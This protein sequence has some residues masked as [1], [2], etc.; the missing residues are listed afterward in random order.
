MNHKLHHFINQWVVF[1]FLCF[2]CYFSISTT[3]STSPP[4]TPSKTTPA[5]T[6]DTRKPHLFFQKTF[7]QFIK[8]STLPSRSIGIAVSSVLS[9][10]LP[11]NELAFS[12]HSNQLFVPASLSKIVTMGVLL[13]HFAPFHY[14]ETAFLSRSP[15]FQKK[16]SGDLYLRG[17]G[18]PSFV[19]ESLWNLVNHLTRTNLKIVTGNLVLDDSLF[20]PAVKRNSFFRSD[21]SFNAP[22]SA[23]SFNWNSVNVYVRPGTHAKDPVIVKADPESQYIQVQNTAQTTH[24]KNKLKVYRVKKNN[25]KDT[26][27]V[28]GFLPVGTKEKV[29]YKNISYPVWWTGHQ[30]LSFLKRRGIHIE[31]QL[32]K[33]KTPSDATVMAIQK[34]RSLFQLIQDMMKFSSNFIAEMLMIQLSL[35]KG[36]P[37]GSLKAGL[38]WVDPYLKHHQI[39]K[40]VF[41]QPSGLSRKNKLKPK[42]LLHLLVKDFYSLSAYEK[43]SSY[44]VGTEGTLKKRFKNLIHPSQVRA[45]TGQLSGVEGLA[46]YVTNQKNQTRAFVFIYNGSEKKKLMARKLFDQFVM[47][48][49]NEKESSQF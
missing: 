23:L 44:P 26:I 13:E 2:H 25:Y 43:L 1:V 24:H 7:R 5:H 3:T 10:S 32:Q 31:G 16:I 29:I 15:I 12:H 39:H 30:A 36:E 45:K 4:S 8:N 48:L 6:S 37:V 47:M 34:G 49:A 33:G 9:R 11:A 27:Y 17:G 38:K 42:D 28:K 22:S 18:D 14:F 20:K 19:S 21:R 41:Q 40:Y 46:G 35:Y